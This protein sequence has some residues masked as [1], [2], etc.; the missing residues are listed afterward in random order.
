M[1]NSNAIVCLRL[2]RAPPSPIAAGASPCRGACDWPHCETP[3]RAELRGELAS[4]RVKKVTNNA[5]RLPPE[6][7]PRQRERFARCRCASHSLCVSI[8][9]KRKEDAGYSSPVGFPQPPEIHAII[10]V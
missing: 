6:A 5:P 10:V 1:P 2:P 9:L 4:T 8:V 7:L 3:G